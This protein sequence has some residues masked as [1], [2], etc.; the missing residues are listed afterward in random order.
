MLKNATIFLVDD[1]FTTGATLNEAARTLKKSGA[2]AVYG[3]AL[4]RDA[5]DEIHRLHF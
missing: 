2:K 3:L 5:E 1:I 4:A